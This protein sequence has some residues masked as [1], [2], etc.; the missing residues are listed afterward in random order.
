MFGRQLAKSVIVTPHY[1]PSARALNLEM[2]NARIRTLTKLYQ[3]GFGPHLL[4]SADAI[5][6]LTEEEEM[7]YKTWGLDKVYFIPPGVDLDR[8]N[9]RN[10]GEEFKR[11]FGIQQ[12]T[13]ILCVARL[14]PQKGIDYL[15]KAG[16]EVC[17][18]FPNTVFVVVGEGPLKSHLSKL[19]RTLN[20]AEFV[21]FTGYISEKLLPEA[22]AACDL[23]VLPSIGEPFGIVLLEAM[24]SGKPIVATNIGGVREIMKKIPESLVPPADEY[25]LAKTIS[26]FLYDKELASRVA[27]QCREIAEKSYGWANIAKKIMNVYINAVSAT[28]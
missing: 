16:V 23:F 3:Y 18:E 20:I 10:Q 4:K 17:K 22:Y 15:L 21:L 26:R 9:P 8:F 11:K 1:N 14:I 24:A 6:A 5:I 19:A 12:K 28:S 7:L 2:L 25:S 27:C 13:I